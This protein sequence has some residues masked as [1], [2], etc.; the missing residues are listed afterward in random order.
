[1][2]TPEGDKTDPDP[3]REL[4]RIVPER[5]LVELAEAI[6]EAQSRTRYGAITIIIADGRIVGVDREIK[7]R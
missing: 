4:C 1:M 6:C 3:I 5:W 2:T 7:T